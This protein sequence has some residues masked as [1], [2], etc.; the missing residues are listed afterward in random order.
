[1]SLLSLSAKKTAELIHDGRIFKHTLDDKTSAQV[2]NELKSRAGRP[3]PFAK[4]KLSENSTLPSIG[5]NYTELMFYLPHG[6]KLKNVERLAVNHLDD[7]YLAFVERMLTDMDVLTKMPYTLQNVLDALVDPD[8]REKLRHLKFLSCALTLT[9][10]M[11]E[12]I[13][14]K[15]TNLTALDFT[16]TFLKSH[17]LMHVASVFTKLRMLSIALTTVTSL[18]GIGQLKDLEVLNMAGVDLEEEEDIQELRELKKLRVLELSAIE[19]SGDQ[20]FKLY[21]NCEISL[22]ELRFLDISFHEITEKQLQTLVASHPKI[23]QIGLIGTPLQEREPHTNPNIRLVTVENLE[24]C[25]K[26]FEDLNK[27][28]CREVRKPKQEQVFDAMEAILLGD[29]DEQS[30]IVLRKC[31]DALLPKCETIENWMAE[32]SIACL[33]QMCKDDRVNM[34]NYEEIQHLISMLAK[35][36]ERLFDI[37]DVDDPSFIMQVRIWKIFNFDAVF[38]NSV[39]NL[40][41]LCHKAIDVIG[42]SFELKSEAEYPVENCVIFLHRC[43][44]S[45]AYPGIQLIEEKKKELVDQV[46]SY[47]E[48]IKIFQEEHFQDLHSFFTQL[49][50]A[51]IWRDEKKGQV[52]WP[53]IFRLTRAIVKWITNLRRFND[54]WERQLNIL[55]QKISLT[56]R[57]RSIYLAMFFGELFP[58][59]T[60]LI[61]TRGS[62]QQECGVTLF[63]AIKVLFEIPY[64]SKFLD[65]MKG[66][67]NTIIG[68]INDVNRYKKKS[69]IEDKLALYW[70]LAENGS[71]ETVEWAEWILH[72]FDEVPEPRCKRRLPW[73]D[74]EKMESYYPC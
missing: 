69:R 8:S 3:A 55:I 52:S 70:W 25:L 29:Y 28:N 47:M 51:V 23:I 65:I 57:L 44:F 16:G 14:Q 58:T 15:F 9:R 73:E 61:L 50:A 41:Y 10:P 2:S 71:E 39:D 64:Q 13:S 6:I 19:T 27:D 5:T 74:E 62:I 49:A 42:S 35:A 46:L 17:E 45:D 34:F 72:H 66:E 38:K 68:I 12:S 56:V 48:H 24:C 37:A 43:F 60:R 26:A 30:E 7:E 67:K 22:P 54:N 63:Y 33:Y 59:L 40:E 53:N 4:L 32:E 20:N 36:S 21:M 31:F 18:N 11:M 1:M